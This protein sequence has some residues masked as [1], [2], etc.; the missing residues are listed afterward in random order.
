MIWE[1]IKKRKESP[2]IEIEGSKWWRFILGSWQGCSFGWLSSLL[3]CRSWLWTLR[4][5]LARLRSSK[6][7]RT[8]SGA[9]EWSL[10][11]RQFIFSLLAHIYGKLLLHDLIYLSINE[12]LMLE[13]GSGIHRIQVSISSFYLYLIAWN[14]SFPFLESDD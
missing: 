11:I 4:L 2:K 13:S 7:E 6:F 3:C 12:S 14:I 1:I 8:T 10:Y 9:F 5:R